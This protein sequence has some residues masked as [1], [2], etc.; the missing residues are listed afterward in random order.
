MSKTITLTEAQ[1]QPLF[2]FIAAFDDTTTGAWIGVEEHMRE[3]FGIED[4]E[5]ALED[6]KVALE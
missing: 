4:P 3:V 6:A 5:A 1:A 2:A